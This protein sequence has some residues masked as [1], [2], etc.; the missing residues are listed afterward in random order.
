M[1]IPRSGIALSYGNSLF[2]FLRDCQ[3]F[4]IAEF[5]IP[6]SNVQCLLYLNFNCFSILEFFIIEVFYHKIF[7]MYSSESHHSGKTINSWPVLAYLNLG[8]FPASSLDYCE[9]N[10]RYH[11]K[12]KIF[13]YVFSKDKDSKNN[14]NILTHV[15]NTSSISTNIQ[16]ILR[17][18]SLFTPPSF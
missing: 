18:L 14:H 5:Y 7:L 6:I 1:A 12:Y 2:N 15:K 11:I 10:H 16:L 4:T 9:A 8:P 13:Q 3:F 17:S